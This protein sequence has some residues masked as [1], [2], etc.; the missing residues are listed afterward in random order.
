V[1]G[2]S[3]TALA[4]IGLSAPASSSSAEQLVE[5]FAP[6]LIVAAQRTAMA[7]RHRD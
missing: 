6:K 7:L 3:G 4:T 5:R 1:I 2:R